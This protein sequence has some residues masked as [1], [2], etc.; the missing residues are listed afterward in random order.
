V[1]VEVAG[2][3]ICIDVQIKA[4]SATAKNHG[5]FSAMEVRN[6]RP[7]FMYVFYSEAADSYWV[8][9]SLDL[10]REANCNKGGTNLGKYSII[11]TNASAESQPRPRPRFER[12]RN[13]LESFEVMAAELSSA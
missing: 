2:H 12:W 1:R 11:F 3:P 7:N 5:T 13:H 6:P 10:I 4:R 8:M 9:P